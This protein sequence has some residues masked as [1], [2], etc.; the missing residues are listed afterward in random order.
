MSSNPTGYATLRL[1]LRTFPGRKHVD[2]ADDRGYTPVHYAA[3]HANFVAIEIIRDH[4]TS[5]GEEIDLNIPNNEGVPPLHG[6]GQLREAMR[7]NEEEHRSLLGVFK[8]NS[9]QTYV[10]MR[11]LGARFAHEMTESVPLG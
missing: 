11:S 2:M 1:L 9:M 10:R 5:I 3:Y 8:R 6:V 7:L 4:L